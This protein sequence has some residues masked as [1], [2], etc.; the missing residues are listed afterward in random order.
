MAVRDQRVPRIRRI[1]DIVTDDSERQTQQRYSK[2]HPRWYVSS[3]DAKTAI[4]IRVP[5]CRFRYTPSA[6]DEPDGILWL[7][8]QWSG[9]WAAVHHRPGQPGPYRVRQFGSRQLFD[10]VSAAYQEWKNAGKPPASAW[11]IT[12]T[13][14]RQRAELPS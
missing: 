2:R 14:D 1:N 12:I 6:D 13:P 5:R 4:G 3:Y 7:L 9:S 11:R 8:D 10:E